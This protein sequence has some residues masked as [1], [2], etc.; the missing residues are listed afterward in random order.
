MVLPPAEEV[1]CHNHPQTRQ[2]FV[3]QPL[4]CILH[5]THYTHYKITNQTHHI[6]YITRITQYTFGTYMC[7]SPC[8]IGCDQGISYAVATV[9]G[10]F[11]C[12][13][14]NQVQLQY[15]PILL[16]VHP[17]KPSVRYGGKSRHR[18][19]YQATYDRC[20][21]FSSHYT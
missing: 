16:P 21:I 10:Q 9:S 11:E 15:I 12:D 4:A 2:P 1:L 8:G 5:I 7:C 6:T 14:Y 17:R 3:E 19:Q 20:H 13:L 18:G